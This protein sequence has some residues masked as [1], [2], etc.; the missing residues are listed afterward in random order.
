MTLSGSRSLDLVAAHFDHGLREES[1]REAEGVA[2]RC[3][4]VGVPC[5]IG[6]PEERPE[7][8][9]EALRRARYRFLEEEADR[10]GA[11]RVATGHQADDQVETIL[12]RL[13]RGT[14][15]RGLRGI[16]E[17]RG[18]VVRPLL[19]FGR[20]ELQAWLE[21]RGVS[22]LD[23]P[24]NRDPRWSRARLR[25]RTV[26]ALEE[27]WGG[28]LHLR[29]RQ[30][31]EVAGRAD[32]ALDRRARTV[33][34]RALAGRG[35]PWGEEAFRLR[36][37]P[38]AAAHP[39]VRARCVRILARRLDVRVTGGGTREAVQFISEGRSGGRVDLGGGL[40]IAREFDRLWLGRPDEP[41]PDT[42]LVL[43]GPRAGRG[44]VLVGGRRLRVE[45]G[46][47][48]PPERGGRR[49]ALARDRLRFPLRLRS[50][51]AGDRL[52]SGGRDRKL[53]ELFRDR[54]VPVSRRERTAVLADRA[55]RVLWVEGL[56]VD[57]RAEARGDE[58]TFVTRIQDV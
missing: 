44:S 23:D 39:E 20:G 17:R 3:R 6:R 34:E 16:P 51:R 45:W 9:Q 53:K 8:T 1:R 40:Q 49:V 15:L 11:D 47:G 52:R 31:S 30:L 14:G 33:L 24:S 26:P 57:P 58:P 22:W 32:R 4:A 56:G 13:E 50:R 29:L 12:F 18:R 38:L 42:V 41:A 43:E 37:D 48:G 35:G 10:L 25:S 21:E 7:A 5:R 28:P 36:R 46:S 27:A 54:R 55:G 2:R 19:G